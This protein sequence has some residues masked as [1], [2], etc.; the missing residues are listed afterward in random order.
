MKN[1]SKVLR[2]NNSHAFIQQTLSKVYELAGIDAFELQ[3]HIKMM[4]GA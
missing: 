4:W 1:F 2:M 3:W